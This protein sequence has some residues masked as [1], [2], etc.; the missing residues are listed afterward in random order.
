MNLFWLLSMVAS[1]KNKDR[2]R[3]SWM[4]KTPTRLLGLKRRTTTLQ[5]TRITL[6][7]V[8]CWG[9]K[10]LMWM[11]VI[12]EWCTIKSKMIQSGNSRST[13]DPGR[14]LSTW[15]GLWPPCF[16][17]HP[18]SAL[19]INPIQLI[20]AWTSDM[21]ELFDHSRSNWWRHSA[22]KSSKVSQDCRQWD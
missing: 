12:M 22:L 9:L 3:Y 21:Q 2:W 14:Y 20:S 5:W 4:F 13:T 18:L 11:M 19:T 17:D 10:Q 7:T 8:L 6:L 1:L 16:N 15:V